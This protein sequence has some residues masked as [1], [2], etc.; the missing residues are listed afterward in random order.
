MKHLKTYKVFESV[1]KTFV[2]TVYYYGWGRLIIGLFGAISIILLSLFFKK[3]MVIKNTIPFYNIMINL[4][5]KTSYR[6]SKYY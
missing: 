2:N 5:V 6:R 3:K 4:N 1:D